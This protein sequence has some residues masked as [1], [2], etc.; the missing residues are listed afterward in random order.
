MPRTSPTHTKPV[1]SAIKPVQTTSKTLK[2]NSIKESINQPATSQRPKRAARNH[3]W[4]DG[5]VK[6][7]NK[8]D[9]AVN[10]LSVLMAKSN[11]KLQQ[12]FRMSLQ[13][14]LKQTDRIDSVLEAIEGE[15][16]N[17]EKGDVMPPIHYNQIL[18][19]TYMF[20]KDKYKSNGEY[21][22]A[23]ARLVA[24]GSQQNVADVGDTTSPTVNPITV[25][26]LL[27]YAASQKEIKI[28]A[29]D[30][31]HAF[32]IPHVQP[33]KKIYV[34]IRKDLVQKWIKKYPYRSKY[35]TQ[36]GNMYGMLSHYLYGLQEASKEFNELLS[37]YLMSLGFTQSKADPC[38]YTHHHPKHGIMHAAIHVDDILLIAPNKIQQHWFESSMKKQFELVSQYD[39]V[40]Y[41]GMSISRDKA[42]G[43]I[44]V[45]HDG[46]VKDILKKYN[47]DKLSKHPQ[48]P[49]T[50]TLYQHDDS[51]PTCDKNKYL[52][53]TMTLMYLARPISSCRFRTW[54][55]EVLTQ[56]TKTFQ[57]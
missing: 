16:D 15:I 51:S 31:K 49:A 20:L 10:T 55:L 13:K 53:L 35:V 45:V 11:C 23:K 1:D 37:K 8:N 34:R 44:R 43:N 18:I 48:T 42:T 7:R 12:A 5:S 38:L 14:V 17:M 57:S 41:L 39:N 19:F 27:N 32:L 6:L 33:G 50:A 25:M 24:N 28:S 30:F 22:K 52:S 4:K 29:Y 9:P 2:Q 36:A 40:S 46:Y 47:C 54:K 56:L 26:V 3:D 21:D